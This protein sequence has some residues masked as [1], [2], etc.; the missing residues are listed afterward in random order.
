MITL[1][2]ATV[3]LVTGLLGIAVGW[4]V[5]DKEHR[6]KN[7]ELFLQALQYLSGG[8]QNRNLGISA[9]ELYQVTRRHRQLC[10]TLLTGSA[11]YL[12]N[13]SKQK[14]AAHE[15]FNLKRIMAMLLDTEHPADVPEIH[16]RGLKA[17][18]DT[19][20]ALI[21]SRNTANPPRGVH[22][23]PVELTEWLRL[24]DALLLRFRPDA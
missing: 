18:L 14:T 11:I 6:Q 12:L 20:I 23:D 19:A 24:T 1:D 8:S 16:L 7:D 13:V 15:L 5:S 22:A 2:E 4:W 10:N 3:A 9:I 17:S 21:P